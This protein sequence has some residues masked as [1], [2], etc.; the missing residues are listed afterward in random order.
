MNLAGHLEVAARIGLE[1]DAQFGA[2]LP[3]FAAI[4]RV[5][6]DKETLT[7]EL[8][9]GV[10]VHHLTDAAFH[11]HHEV[12]ATM[13]RINHA[14]SDRGLSRGAARSVAHV[15]YEMLLD[16]AVDDRLAAVVRGADHDAVSAALRDPDQ[17]PD[18]RAHFA[19]RVAR[20]DDPHWVA[21]RLHAVLR[22]RPRLA[23]P[24]HQVDD[25]AQVLATHH[26]H[27]RSTAGAVF[28]QVTEA[29]S[30]GV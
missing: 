23:F 6:I 7:P 28:D 3:D 11:H 16:S 13:A 5:R 24:R 8:A 12:R 18:V 21:D 17:W 19:T 14:L 27:I 20:Y 15:G 26:P 25:V 4:L 29:A 1:R 30:V 10:K 9:Q 2:I 22:H